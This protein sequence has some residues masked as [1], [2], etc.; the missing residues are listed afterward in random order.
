MN[1]HD[2]HDVFLFADDFSRCQI[3]AVFFHLIHEL[4]VTEQTA[5]PSFF[6]LPCPIVQGFQVGLV[7]IAT[8]H[9]PDEI[10]IGRIIVQALQEF[11][12]TVTTT[13]RTPQIKVVHELLQVFFLIHSIRQRS[14]K[15]RQVLPQ[16]PVTGQADAG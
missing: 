15:G 7:H 6:V 14:G 1:T 13:V 3:Q 12:Y 5:K 8:G 2:A 16:R 10:D 11:R 4:Q 9:S